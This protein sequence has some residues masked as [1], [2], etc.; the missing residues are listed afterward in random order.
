MNIGLRPEHTLSE[1]RPRAHG[2]RRL[3]H[4]A[5]ALALLL[6]ASHVLAQHPTAS[7]LG[8]LQIGGGVALGTSNYNFDNAKLIGGSFYTSF[9]VRKHF[10][11]EFDFHQ[12]SP[13]SNSTVYE[14]TFEVGPRYHINRGAFEPYAKA[15][16]GRGVYNFPSNAANIAYNIYTFG[17]GLDTHLRPS[18]NLR[19]DY[20]YQT[21]P[22]FP[23]ATLHPSIATIGVAYHFHE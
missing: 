9:D 13:T 20:E 15:L 14:R 11:A 19:L 17:G 18:L 23:L 12:A 16:I 22:N 7:R 2:L 6:A 8:D 3:R 4:H 10:G 5:A 1:R 21:W